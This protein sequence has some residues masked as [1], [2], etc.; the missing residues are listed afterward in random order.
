M[1]FKKNLAIA[2]GFILL[3]L[4]LI[5]IEV[6]VGSYPTLKYV[7]FSSLGLI[8]FAFIRVNRTSRNS[9]VTSLLQGTLIAI[10]FILIEITAG[11][12]FKF[13]IGGGL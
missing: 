2:F 13:L 5:I 3:W 11:V 10:L 8:F 12:N 7:Y 4:L 6:K 9:R 1:L